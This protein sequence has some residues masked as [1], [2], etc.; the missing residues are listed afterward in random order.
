[1]PHRLFSNTSLT[2]VVADDEL[3]LSKLSTIYSV[4]SCTNCVSFTN[5]TSSKVSTTNGQNKIKLLCPNFGQLDRLRASS[6]L[7]LF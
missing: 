2:S 3:F 4:E 6:V 7:A 1:M 5:T